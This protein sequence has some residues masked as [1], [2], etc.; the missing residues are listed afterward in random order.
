MTNNRIFDVAVVG[1]GPAGSSA[2]LHLAAQGLEV[3]LL[4]KSTHP[5]YKVCGGGLLLRAAELLPFSA[6]PFTEAACRRVSLHF[7][8]TGRGFVTQRDF[9]VVRMVMRSALDEALWR[10][11]GRR[12][13]LC[14][15][16]CRLQNLSSGPEGV[17]LE[18]SGGTFRA[19]FLVGADGVNS[20]VAHRGGW[21]ASPRA[22]ASLE[23][24]LEVD[25]RA[26]ER[27]GGTARFD[28]DHPR[29][30]YAW[31]FPKKHH[32]SVGLC[33]LNRPTSG[34][35]LRKAFRDYLAKLGVQ[36][37]TEAPVHGA[38]IPLS[39]RTGPLARNR[40]LLAGDAAGLADPVTAEGLTGA[41][42]SGI[43]AA[44]SIIDARLEAGAV[45]ALYQRSLEAGPLAD[46]RV[47]SQLAELLYNH[48]LPRNLLFAFRGQAL[49]EKVTD[50]MSGRRRFA[51]I[52]LSAGGIFRQMKKM[53]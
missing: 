16:G 37:R 35:A 34:K 12:G 19:R 40:I 17:E 46:W 50:I 52:D 9:P 10:E 38:L 42:Q 39:P 6:E 32:L 1:G 31:V 7:M 44:Q 13:A 28:M 53:L 18:T 20:L 51:D 49:C 47:S 26:L 22:V 41:L 3:C 36:G 45:E 33:T 21:G 2:A 25:G 48:P 23:C 11:A 14:L 29:R 4:E 43:L 30:G 24:E 8:S 5:R 15:E 27:F